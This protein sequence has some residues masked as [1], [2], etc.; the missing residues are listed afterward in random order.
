MEGVNFAV[1][2]PDGST[3][4]VSPQRVADDLTKIGV[5]AQVGPSGMD[6]HYQIDGQMLSMPIA[7]ILA[8]K[9]GKVKG[10]GFSGDTSFVDPELRFAIEN[11]PNDQ[12]RKAYLQFALTSKGIENP[13]V[14]GMGTDWGFLDP[15]SKQVRPLTNVAGMDMSDLGMV[16]KEGVRFLGAALG[17]GLGAASGAAA[18]GLAAIPGAVLGAGGGSGTAQTLMQGYLG[19]TDP[20]YRQTIS[21]PQALGDVLGNIGKE[22]LV[23]MAGAAIPGLAGA[24]FSKVAPRL[25]GAFG[26]APISKSVEKVSTLAE[27]GLRLGAGAAGALNVPLGR[28]IVAEMGP[29]LGTAQ[30]GGMLAQAPAAVTRNAPKIANWVRRKFDIPEKAIPD[31][32][33]PFD[34][35]GESAARGFRRTFG[36]E[37]IARK[38]F[39]GP[40][41]ADVLGDTFSRLGRSF[42][43]RRGGGKL[44]EEAA[45]R[46]RDIGVGIG[47]TMEG[48]AT[49]G[50]AL[51]SGIDLGA[52]IGLQALQRTMQAGS[53]AA[54][55]PRLG[56]Q[57]AAP[58]ETRAWGYVPGRLTEEY[59][60]NRGR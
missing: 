59:F 33:R 3:L 18:G 29:G 9:V 43:E 8:E 5:P 58:L 37:G 40:T 6:L 14:Y 60:D 20:A 55:V 35:W 23:D 47:R 17:G 4:D 26:S 15:G 48:I 52:N 34:K 54:S 36:G 16:A 46:G 7:D 27:E 1:E 19:A 30:L 13:E 49:G 31:I 56:A 38:G 50:R 39:E 45:A 44:A 51:E 24:A 28:S 25:A 42:G 10:M 2:Q 22:T 53:L 32:I 12:T 21:N 41:S 11:L 57:F